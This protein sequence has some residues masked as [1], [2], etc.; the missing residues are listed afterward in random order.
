MKVVKK[1]SGEPIGVGDRTLIPLIEYSAYARNIKLED[2][3]EKL[4][5]TGVTVT[6]ISVKVI[7]GKKEWI[8]QIQEKTP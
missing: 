1:I 7:E 8:L 6:P 2:K 4:V 5:V 3:S